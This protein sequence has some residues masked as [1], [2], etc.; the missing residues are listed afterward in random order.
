MCLFVCVGGGG[1]GG[2]EELKRLWREVLEGRGCG[3]KCWR[4]ECGNTSR[5]TLAGGERGK[6]AKW[7][8]L[9]MRCHVGRSTCRTL[10]GMMDTGHR[11]DT[12]GRMLM[13]FFV[14]S[15]G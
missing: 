15:L 1:G 10:V 13:A 2:I 5:H 3:V 8:Q 4:G 9:Q 11:V 7:L 6:G 14:C 12:H